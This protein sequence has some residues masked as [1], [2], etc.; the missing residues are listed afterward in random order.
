[1]KVKNEPIKILLIEDDEEDYVITRNLFA[2][3]EGQGFQ[4]EWEASYAAAVETIKAGRHDIY[5]TDY[6]L[7]E[8][9]GLDLVRLVV[10]SGYQGLAIMLTGKGG[11]P[12]D[13]EATMAG[14]ADYLAKD[15]VTSVLL[16]R[17]IRHALERKRAAEA[18]QLSEQRYRD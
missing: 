14:A 11:H 10:A 18:L 8:H 2:Q 9:N 13:I 1:M 4:L 7:G 12:V 3:I 15:S 6:R 5:L 17:S 16:E